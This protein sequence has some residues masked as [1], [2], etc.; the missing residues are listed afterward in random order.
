MPLSLIFTNDWE[1]FGDG[2]GDYFTLQHKPL[3]DMLD[4]FDSYGA[5]ISVMAEVGQQ[6]AHKKLAAQYGWASNISKAWEEILCET[7]KRGHD[8]QLHLHP[9][10]LGAVHD[11]N[12]WK[13][14]NSRWAISSL[15]PDGIESALQSGKDYLDSIFKPV[16]NDYECNCY[17]AGAYYIE[18]SEIVID[19]LKRIGF[20][21]DTSVTKG[22]VSKPHYDYS[23]ANS[24]ILPWQISDKSVKYKSL[25]NNGL[26]ELPI[27]SEIGYDSEAL[28]KY[29]PEFYYRLKF[30][31]NVPI[32]EIDWLRSRDALKNKLYP[33]EN[34]YYKTSEK[35]N[36]L[37]YASK[38][39]SKSAIQLDY[40]YLPATAFTAI[41]SRIF[42]NKLI[43]K[44]LNH[45]FT[46]PVVASGHVKDMPDC[47]NIE[48]I[49]K[50]LKSEFGS[51]IIF[52]T[53]TQARQAAD[54]IIESIN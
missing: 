13:L 39:L 8:V 33:K 17:R 53:L 48:K 28:K 49:L 50:I 22:L 11:G 35:K 20:R 9:Q 19:K 16:K 43:I 32:D 37:W 52:Q 1:L 2:S 29:A 6:L 34:R 4:I 14:D 5:K 15:P 27:Y 40:D 41:I 25:S 7:L 3:A 47:R 54:E 21:C 10:W 24:N 44:Y 30:G 42:R 38:F 23:D 26:I 51:D 31:V 36:L 18:P 46:V 45:G 12:K